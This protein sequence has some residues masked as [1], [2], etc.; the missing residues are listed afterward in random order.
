MYLTPSLIDTC[1]ISV[2]GLLCFVVYFLKDLTREGLWS[3]CWLVG[4][5]SV[6]VWDDGRTGE[7]AGTILML[8]YLITMISLHKSYAYVTRPVKINH[9]YKHKK[10]P[11]LLSFL[12]HNLVTIYT[13]EA[14]CSLLMQNLMGF[15]LQFTEMGCYNHS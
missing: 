7:Y 2:S 8:L 14:K 15:L 4:T 6:N 12:Y 10:L 1:V 5:R 13:N 11:I 9:V 3:E